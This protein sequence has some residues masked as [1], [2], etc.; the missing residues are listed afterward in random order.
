VEN[1]GTLVTFASAGQLPIEEFGLPVRN[2]VAG[3]PSREFWSPGSTLKITVDNEHP[4]G[5]GMPDSALAMFLLGNHAYAVTPGARNHDVRRIA[6]FI[7]RDILRSGWLLG[8]DRIANKAAMV[9]V[10]HGE[11]TVVLIGFRVHHRAQTHGTFKLVFNALVG[12]MAGPAEVAGGGD[13]R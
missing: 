9:S 2:V 8:E 13:G 10:R 4:L 7:D 1:G 11:G 5:Y 12:A 6:S 3:V